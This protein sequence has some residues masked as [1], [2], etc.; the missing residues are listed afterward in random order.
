VPL[1]LV[2]AQQR[3]QFTLKAHFLMVLLLF[4]NVANDFRQIG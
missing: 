1:D 3:S 2:L 4:L